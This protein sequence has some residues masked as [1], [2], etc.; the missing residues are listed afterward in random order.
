[1]RLAGMIAVA[2]LSSIMLGACGGPEAATAP[3]VA[4]GGALAGDDALIAAAQKISDAIG[5]C[6]R[7]ADAKLTSK[8]VGLEGGSIV[9]IGCSQ[10]D[11]TTTSRLFAVSGA[12]P[13]QLLSIPDYGPGGW[14]ASDQASMAEIDAGTGV[15]TTM[16]KGAENGNCGSEGTY[17][18]DGKRM[19]LQEMHWQACDGANLTGPPFP[20]I[21][22][23][24][25]GAAVDPNGATPAP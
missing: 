2:A 21:W 25:Q 24:Q 18:W 5:G 1:M 17:H 19:S 7:P 8:V 14:F 3:T 13:P 22:P 9:M 23:T 15:M 10:A 6:V 4:A 16:R 11:F 12:A 20:V